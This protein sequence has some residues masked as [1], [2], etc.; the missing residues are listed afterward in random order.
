MNGALRYSDFEL[1]M[2]V[3]TFKDQDAAWLV[4]C[5]VEGDGVVAFGTSDA[6]HGQMDFGNEERAATRCTMGE[7]EGLTSALAVGARGLIQERKTPGREVDYL[8]GAIRNRRI[9]MDARRG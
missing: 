2:T 5:L 8:L 4:L 1:L 3:A 9:D 7:R 6:F